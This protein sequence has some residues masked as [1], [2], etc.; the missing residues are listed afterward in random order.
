MDLEIAVG[1][2]AGKRPLFKAR[3]QDIGVT[4]T[5]RKPHSTHETSLSKTKPS[6]L[7]ANSCIWFPPLHPLLVWLPSSVSLA[8]LLLKRFLSYFTDI[9]FLILLGSHCSPCWIIS[10]LLDLTQEIITCTIE[11]NCRTTCT[12]MVWTP[13]RNEMSSRNSSYRAV[14]DEVCTVRFTFRCLI[15]FFISFLIFFLIYTW[16]SNHMHLEMWCKSIP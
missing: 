1:A 5:K 12:V 13:Y 3:L 2:G 15:F 7:A 11:Y 16:N 8:A 14:W 6:L 9:V 10:W 4:L